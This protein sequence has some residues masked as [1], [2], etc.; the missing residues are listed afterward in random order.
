MNQ[1]ITQLASLVEEATEEERQRQTLKHIVTQ[2]KE[3]WKDKEMQLEV[4]FFMYGP[5]RI[6]W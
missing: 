6:G 1:V 3:Q 5:Y 2:L 4:N